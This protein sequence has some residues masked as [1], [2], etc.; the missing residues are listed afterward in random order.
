MPYYVYAIRLDRDAMIR[1]TGKP[2]HK[3]CDQNDHI[4]WDYPLHDG[5]DFYYVGQS[6]HKP[7]CRFAQHK[8]CYGWRIKFT[9]QCGN[10]RGKGKVITQNRSNR[11][12]RDYGLFLSHSL[13]EH[14]NP[15]KSRAVAEKLEAQLASELRSNGHAAYYN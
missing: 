10:A 6:M 8:E 2:P 14:H 9:C 13:F 3:F 15:I 12:A 1:R 4:D 11:F 5:C 7:E